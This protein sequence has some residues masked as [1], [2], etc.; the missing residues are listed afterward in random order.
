[1]ILLNEM[2]GGKT[3]DRISEDHWPNLFR[4]HYCVNY[5]RRL[6]G[7][8]L[9]V[10]SGYRTV[11]DQIRIYKQKGVVE[12]A[13]PMGSCHLIGAAIDLYDPRKEFQRWI[14]ENLH[15]AETLDVYFEEFDSTPNWVHIQIFPPAS[16]KRFFKP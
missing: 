13:I 3:L 14:L 5:L 11:E 2:L 8:A 4:L 6:Y 10:S 1:M 12:S 9:T 16:R 15:F 7:K